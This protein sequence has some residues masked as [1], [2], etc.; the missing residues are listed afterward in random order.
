MVRQIPSE[1]RRRVLELWLDGN[2]YRTIHVETDVSVGAISLIIDEERKK[3][4]DIDELSRLRV[5]LKQ[6]GANLTDAFR[7]AVFL[8][9]LNY[10]N[11]QIDR[12]PVC[13]SLLNQYG[14]E[15]GEALES[16][17]RLKELEA[18][19]GKT[20]TQILAEAAEKAKQL[21]DMARS[22]EDLRREE[23]TIKK[24]LQDLEQLK[25]LNEKVNLHSLTLHRLDRFIEQSSRLEELGFT[26][27]VAEILASELPKQG[28]DPQKAAVRLT[29][30]LSEYGSL[31][32][33]VAGLQE[34]TRLQNDIEMKKVQQEDITKQLETLRGQVNEHKSLVENLENIRRNKIVQLEEEYSLKQKGLET[35]IQN[36]ERNREAVEKAT[37]EL[38]D[39][40]EAVQAS[41][42]EA[43]AA[44]TK[45]EE[46]LA[47][48]R[49]LATLSLL[50]EEPESQLDPNTLL[51]VSASVIEGLTAHIKA[52]PSLT[53]NPPEL[54]RKLKEISKTLGTEIRLATRKVE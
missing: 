9:K 20:Y 51:K 15:A 41:L 45:I 47:K 28:L 6:A 43:Q 48:T 16:R 52:N 39:E 26:P 38:K 54:Q 44:L 11:V 25:A 49:P 53:S 35:E 29:G 21:Q 46:K 2:T 5:A 8:E 36:L 27:K 4:P 32:K 31:E 22:V 33:A 42:G 40:G 10:L 19:Q 3:V 34:T 37:R 23:E 7:G 50:M 1:V 18:S 14:E 12:I 13:I 17:R 24:S 30:L